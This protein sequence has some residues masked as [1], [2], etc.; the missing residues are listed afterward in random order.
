MSEEYRCLHNDDCKNLATCDEIDGRNTSCD[1]HKL[2]ENTYNKTIDF[3]TKAKEKHGDKYRYWNVMYI[4]NRTK[5]NIFCNNCKD[6]FLQSPL[7]HLQNHGCKKCSNEKKSLNTRYSQSEFIDKLK[8]KHGDLYDYS[9]VK[10]NGSFED[11]N[12]ICKNHGVFKQKAYI[13]LYGQGC[14]DCAGNK[15]YTTDSFIKKAIEVHGDRY[16]YDISVYTGSNNYVDIICNIHGTFKQNACDHIQGRGCNKCGI[17]LTRNKLSYTTEDFINFAS[18]IH[19]DKYDYSKVNYTLSNIHVTIICKVHNEFKQTPS[20]HLSG[21]GCPKCRIINIQNTCL[22]KY[23]VKNPSQ[24]QSVREKVKQ[25]CLNKYGVEYTTQVEEFKEKTKQTCLEKY[26]VEYISQSPEIRIKA[27]N[28]NFKRYGVEHAAQSQEIQEKAQ[29]NAKK[30]KEYKT[31]SGNI[32]RVQGYEPY[33]LDELLKIYTEDQIY[34]QRRDVPRIEYTVDGKQKYY[35]PDIYIPHENRII[36]VKSTWTYNCKTD[37]IKHKKE[38]TIKEG[39]NYEIW[40]YD[41]KG[42]RISNLIDTI[43][44]ICV[45]Y[46]IVYDENETIEQLKEKLLDYHNNVA[47]LTNEELD[48]IGYFE[49]KEY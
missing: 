20:S 41:K 31:T 47:P 13:H 25:T 43:R 24:I 46:E 48:Y 27:Q 28:T 21:Q 32:W 14:P 8:N 23:G 29:K 44:V 39:Y 38:A 30:Y 18:N 6:Y 33:A 45:T 49:N 9:L 3:I 22:E 16:K 17:E 42:Q 7:N 5:I 10:Y 35:F 40:I 12:I 37:N 4:N 34:I 26:G 2:D 15:K 11:I 1:I 19:G 36:E